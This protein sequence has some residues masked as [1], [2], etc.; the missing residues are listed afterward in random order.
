MN[1]IPHDD[2]R[3]GVWA[4]FQNPKNLPVST[5]M[6]YMV[7]EDGDPI[8]FRNIRTGPPADP[9]VPLLIEAVSLPWVFCI[10]Y[11][12]EKLRGMKFDLRLWP[13]EAIEAEYGESIAN[14]TKRT[15]PDKPP[16]NLPF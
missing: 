9:G 8:A 1:E 6:E 13:I 3:P 12:I 15:R 14:W 7:D 5:R 4:T 16:T 2:I 10:A 11:E